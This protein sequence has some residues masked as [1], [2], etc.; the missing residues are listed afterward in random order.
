MVSRILY[1][2][3]SVCLGRE[4]EIL[5]KINFKNKQTYDFLLHLLNSFKLN[6]VVIYDIELV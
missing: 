5:D 1:L 4:I 2:L 3:K 6:G